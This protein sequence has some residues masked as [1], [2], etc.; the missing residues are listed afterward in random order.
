MMECLSF[1]SNLYGCLCVV[2]QPLDG[3]SDAT[4]RLLYGRGKKKKR[5]KKT[6]L[7]SVYLGLNSEVSQSAYFLPALLTFVNR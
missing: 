7:C 3:S 5:K 2:D 4:I 6:Q 1:T